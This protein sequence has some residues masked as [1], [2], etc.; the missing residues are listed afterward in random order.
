MRRSTQAAEGTLS[1][2]ATA[3]LATSFS[4]GSWAAVA[5]AHS[6][7]GACAAA[8]GAAADAT[9]AAAAAAAEAEAEAAATR[10]EVGAAHRAVRCNLTQAHR[11]HPSCVYCSFACHSS[12]ATHDAAPG[13]W[14]C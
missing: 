14:L 1:A 8:A 4:R 13:M 3:L 6:V 12:F 5:R 7:H 11:K 2:A 9:R 10:L